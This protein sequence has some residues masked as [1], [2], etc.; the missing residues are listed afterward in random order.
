MTYRPDIDGLRAVAVISVILFHLNSSWLPGGFLGVDIFFV[1]SGYLIG[2]ILFRELSTKTFSLKNFYLRRMRRILPAFF[3]VV[4]V[5]LLVGMFLM[6]PGSNESTSLKQIA[7]SSLFF[8][9]NLFCSLKGG[10]FATSTEMQPLNH[11]WSLAVEEQFYLIYPLVLWGI[12]RLVKSFFGK[13]YVFILSAFFLALIIISFSLAFLPVYFRG[14]VVTAYYLPHL[15][16]G[17]LLMGAGYSIILHTI[18]TKT[19]P[20]NSIVKV[21]T[22]HL[23]SSSITCNLLGFASFCLLLATLILPFPKHVPWF[24]GFAAIIPCIATIGIIHSGLSHHSRIS[25]ILSHS[26]TVY[27][28]KLS[29]SLYLWHW[30]V[31][32][33]SRYILQ[34][35]LSLMQI[36][37]CMLLCLCLSVLSYYMIENRFR[38]KDWGFNKTFGFYYVIP[39]VM[40]ILLWFITP[41]QSTMEPYTVCGAP[42][43]T[44]E[45]YQNMVVGDSTKIPNVLIA[46]D[47]Y[48][49]HLL[50][51]VQKVAKHEGWSAKFSGMHGTPFLL[52]YVLPQCDVDKDIKKIVSDRNSQL[53][54]KLGDYKTVILSSHWTQYYTPTFK[55]E[56]DRTLSYLT[57]HGH[58]TIMIFST[59]SFETSRLPET[60]ARLQGFSLPVSFTE[61]EIKG[62]AFYEGIAIRK[63]LMEH[64]KMNFP[65]VVCIDLLPLVPKDL[66][67]DGKSVMRDNYHLS[68]FGAQYIGEQFIKKGY[69]L[70]R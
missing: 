22:N 1:I 48:T 19:E 34:K 47:S 24:P 13:K 35:P 58:H 11:L 17:E 52:D 30:P 53:M 62:K 60:F 55:T 44:T 8:A 38:R 36:F 14:S 27:I 7:L 25:K 59:P 28:G 68:F 10:Y 45:Q 42:N 65:N 46:G 43:Y 50:G 69:H 12:L 37:Y 31:L 20:I 32:A 51:F 5:C 29:Y 4:I 33:F 70:V 23:F 6:I 61:K 66:M 9:G 40:T 39:G 54:S 63:Q 57:T 2:G 21:K 15:R 64:I 56:L 49:I 26:I 41:Y 3:A 67:V 16:F 18:G